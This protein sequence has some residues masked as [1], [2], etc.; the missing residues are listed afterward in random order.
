LGIVGVQKQWKHMAFQVNPFVTIPTK[1]VV[2]KSD[3]LTMG[4]QLNFLF[5]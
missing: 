1:S 2:Y 5:R 4:L 3:K